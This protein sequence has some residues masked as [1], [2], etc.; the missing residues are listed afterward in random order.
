MSDVRIKQIETYDQT[1]I[2]NLESMSRIFYRIMIPFSPK[3][4]ITF[5]FFS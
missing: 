1:P 2:F 3:A 5:M 4:G